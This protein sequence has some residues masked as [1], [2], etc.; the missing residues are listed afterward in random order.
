MYTNNLDNLTLDNNNDNAEEYSEQYWDVNTNLV[1]KCLDND[2]NLTDDTN[3]DSD[4]SIED[5]KS[6][7]INPRVHKRDTLRQLNILKDFLP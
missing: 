4:P 7:S 1:E 3:V 6:E 5:D 2:S